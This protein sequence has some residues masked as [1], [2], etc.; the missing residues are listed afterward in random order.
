MQPIATDGVVWSVCLSLLRTYVNP[1][2]TAEL[3][4]IPTGGSTWVDP[5]SHVLDGSQHRTNPFGDAAFLQNSLTTSHYFRR[6]CCKCEYRVSCPWRHLAW[7][8]RTPGP[9]CSHIGRRWTPSSGRHEWSRRCPGRHGRRS[10][11]PSLFG[12]RSWTERRESS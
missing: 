6:C 5:R 8:R 2:E 3:I 11:K 9:C 4:E 10:Y 12:R 1:E 7:R